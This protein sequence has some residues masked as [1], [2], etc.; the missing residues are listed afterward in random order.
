MTK[1]FSAILQFDYPFDERTADETAARGFWEL[2]HV[3]LPDGTRHPIVFYDAVRLAQ[4]LSEEASQ[5]RPFL[6]ERSMIVLQEVTRKNMEAAVEQLAK[7]GFF[8]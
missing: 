3:M 1:S 8:K 6:S 5:G 4:D 2:C 7:E